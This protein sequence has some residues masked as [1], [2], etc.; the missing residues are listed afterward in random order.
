MSKVLELGLVRPVDAT[1]GLV[2]KVVRN[3]QV[4]L[5]SSPYR[6]LPQVTAARRFLETS[7]S[8]A[9]TLQ[10]FEDRFQLTE[11]GP[12]PIWKPGN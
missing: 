10:E 7:G 9:L 2:K 1:I 12:V 4:V 8:D 11:N 3:F 5:P 6:E